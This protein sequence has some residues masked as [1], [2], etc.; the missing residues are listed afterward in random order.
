MT[1]YLKIVL[2]SLC[3]MAMVLLLISASNKCEIERLRA[4]QDSILVVIDSLGIRYKCDNIETFLFDAKY[5]RGE[6]PTMD[7]STGGRNEHNRK[8]N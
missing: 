7:T 6:H 8:D 1:T 5:G 2:L 4:R 3:A